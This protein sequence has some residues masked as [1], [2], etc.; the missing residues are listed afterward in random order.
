MFASFVR[1][2]KF[3]DFWRISQKDKCQ[4]EC[5]IEIGNETKENWCKSGDLAILISLLIEIGSENQKRVNK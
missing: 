4:G 1:V 5:Y 2:S 3:L